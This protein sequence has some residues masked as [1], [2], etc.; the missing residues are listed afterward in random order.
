LF[1]Q[2]DANKIQAAAERA[3]KLQQAVER[4]E[5]EVT[6]LRKQVNLCIQF[7]L[8]INFDRVDLLFSWFALCNE[9]Y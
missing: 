7:F 1:P 8:C 9:M 4:A 6:A 3:N 5:Q 2:V